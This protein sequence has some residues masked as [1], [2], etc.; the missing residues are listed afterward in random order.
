[1]HPSKI[2]KGKYFV[3]GLSIH[4]KYI[5]LIIKQPLV[6]FAILPTSIHCFLYKSTSIIPIFIRIRTSNFEPR[7]RHH[8]WNFPLIWA[9]FEPYRF[10]LQMNQIGQRP[11]IYN[12]HFSLH[13]VFFT[14]LQ[15]KRVRDALSSTFR[16]TISVSCSVITHVWERTREISAASLPRHG[17]AR[18]ET[19]SYND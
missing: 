15:P 5:K 2:W 9:R 7:L 4:S 18:P 10:S 16:I 14:D 12:F 19:H 13:L 8:S 1:M 6:T 11:E 3:R 17:L